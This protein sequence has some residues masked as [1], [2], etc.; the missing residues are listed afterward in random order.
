M[1]RLVVQIAVIAVAVLDVVVGLIEP[2]VRDPVTG[3]WMALTEEQRMN[4]P[5]FRDPRAPPLDAPQQNSGSDMFGGLTILSNADATPPVRSLAIPNSLR[6]GRT[7]KYSSVM[8]IGA[9]IQTDASEAVENTTPATG[10]SRDELWQELM[11]DGT[12]YVQAFVHVN[13][14]PVTTPLSV[15]V[16]T[17]GNLC[18]FQ[19]YAPLSGCPM[20]A[21]NG[22]I[23]R[24]PCTRSC[25]VDAYFNWRCLGPQMIS[26][27]DLARF[28]PS[29]SPIPPPPAVNAQF[30]SDLAGKIRSAIQSGDYNAL[31]KLM[32]SA[33]GL[34]PN[35]ANMAAAALAQVSAKTADEGTEVAETAADQASQDQNVQEPS[36]VPNAGDEFMTPPDNNQMFIGSVENV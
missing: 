36:G 20:E 13:P 31:A 28:K 8:A 5:R 12:P 7:D 6:P 34:A 29:P 24:L 27:Q 30:V 23:D 4:D 17:L 32:I 25:G 9:N 21:K 2:V 18:R 10:T 16:R 3:K 1:S 15:K 22:C 19:G 26:A 11:Q 35:L 14:N 33:Q